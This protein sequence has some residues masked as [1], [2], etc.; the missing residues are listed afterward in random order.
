MRQIPW[1][2]TIVTLVV[3]FLATACAIGIVLFAWAIHPII[4][5]VAIIVLFLLYMAL[6]DFTFWTELEFDG[7]FF[8]SWSYVSCKLHKKFHRNVRV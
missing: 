2:K 8:N 5:M 6:V 7:N 4:G 3:S 1:A